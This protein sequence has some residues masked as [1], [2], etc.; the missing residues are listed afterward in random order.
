MIGFDLCFKMIIFG[1]YLENRLGGKGGNRR[2][3]K[4]FRDGGL[5]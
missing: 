4:E 3:S 2:I 5:G 1:C